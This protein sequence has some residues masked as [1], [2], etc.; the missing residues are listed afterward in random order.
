VEVSIVI[1]STV[2]SG[3]A[4]ARRPMTQ[5]NLNASRHMVFESVLY[6]SSTAG[7]DSHETPETPACFRDL[8]LDRVVG[9]IADGW[10]E[11]DLAP[12]FHTPLPDVEAVV[13]RQE[14]ARELERDD[15]MNAVRAF[16]AAMRVV[17]AHLEQ[18]TKLHYYPYEH[19]RWRLHA[20]ETYCDTLEELQ[21][22][23]VRT[24]PKARGLAALCAYLDAYVGSP[25]FTALARDAR[26]VAMALAGVHYT[27]LLR[28]GS[29]TVQP[30][31]DEPDYTV[32]VE[33]TFEKFRRGSAKD[34]RAKLSGSIGMSQFEAQ[35]LDGI[36]EQ[37][38]EPFS[39][40]DA[41][42]A[43]HTTFIDDTIAR[44]DR[45]VELYVAYLA[46]LQPLKRAGLP[47]CYPM[48]SARSKEVRCR[49]AFDLALATKLVTE[50]GT[51][52]CNDL[53]LH[54]DERIF[55][56]SGPNQGGKTTFA[57]IFGQLHYLAALGAS[58]PRSRSA[59]ASWPDCRSSTWSRRG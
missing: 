22:A 52:V 34:Y 31:A 20:V 57:R 14:V 56:V 49:D 24:Q 16:A 55:V 29:V 2:E 8:H 3:A 42:F 19:E 18:A 30:F 41:F 50:R 47:F 46:Y 51:V 32:V 44:F 53:E 48:V 12:F 9:A 54:G 40:L 58:T 4:A 35:I 13:Y 5:R 28:T 27:L 43:T 59:S 15:V 17:R 26:Q 1:A 25:A 6:P 7:P 11:Y 36:A 23:L 39:A 38:P 10:K 33:T 37:H 21:R 45:E